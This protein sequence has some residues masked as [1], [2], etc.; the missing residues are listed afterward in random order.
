MRRIA[1]LLAFSCIAG[2][3]A[4]AVD[5]VVL[6]RGVS[7]EFF[8]EIECSPTDLCMDSL[9]VWE[10]D[11]KQTLAGPIIKGRVRAV[12]ATHT[13]ATSKYVNSV[14]LFVLKPSERAEDSTSPEFSLIALSPRYRGGKYCLQ[15]D[16]LS[17]GLDVKATRS[18]DGLFCFSRASVL[19]PNKSLERTR[20]R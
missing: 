13:F 9:Y 11:A 14:E 2:V 3:P 16:P 18:T 10:L 17:V 8:A 7:N 6:G 20:A 5:S 1:T 12:I 19:R 15:I 4:W